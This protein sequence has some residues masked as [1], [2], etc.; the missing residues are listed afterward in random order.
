VVV[1]G[2]FL[3]VL[4]M[5]FS[6]LVAARILRPLQRIE[7]TAQ[8]IAGGDLRARV[9]EG[10]FR[11]LVRLAASFNAMTRNLEQAPAELE[12]EVERRTHE[13]QLANA[14]LERLSREDSLTGLANRR[15]FDPRLREEW[16]RARRAGEELSLVVCD[17]D[18][19]KAYNDRY[20]HSAGDEAL[21]RVAGALGASLRRSD[22]LAGRFGGE[23]FVLLLP[24]IGATEA[25][26]FA[27]E[28]REHVL[29]LAIPHEASPRGCV[30]LSFGIATH[31]PASAFPA[32][33]LLYKAADHALYRANAEGRDRIVV[34]DP[35]G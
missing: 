24:G 6:L 35:V 26:R 13:L 22:D 27:R 2:G 11:E 19:F 29:E 16:L 32:P 5:G 33:D 12:T 31:S 4:A 14:E 23:E 25:E 34:A 7:R 8:A 28:I 17:I 30:T 18:H 9:P 10:G 21:R 3:L 20:G 1:L 15:C